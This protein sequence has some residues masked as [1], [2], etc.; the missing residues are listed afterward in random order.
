M[1]SAYW[2]SRAVLLGLF[3][4]GF[5]LHANDRWK[6]AMALGKKA[7]L[8]IKQKRFDEGVAAFAQAEAIYPDGGY[9]ATRLGSLYRDREDYA[10]AMQ[11]YDRALGQGGANETYPLR[12]RGIALCRQ[13][14]FSEALSTFES[15]M[16][17]TTERKENVREAL[18][19][20]GYH[21]LCLRD[22]GR[23]Q[24]AVQIADRG[25]AMS[26]GA[27]IF[28]LAEAKVHSEVWLGHEAIAA[29]RYQEASAHYAESEL[30]GQRS[31][32][33]R[34]WIQKTVEVANLRK[35]ADLRLAAEQSG[36]QPEY[37]HR[38]QVFYIKRSKLDFVASNGQHIAVEDEITSLQRQRSEFFLQ[39]LKKHV[40]AMSGNRLTLDF[41]MKELDTTLTELKRDFWDGREV[42]SP[43]LDS[44]PDAIAKHFCEATQSADTFWI[45]WPGKGAATTANGGASLFP[46]VPYQLYTPMRGYVT[47]PA[48][49]KSPDA[50]LGYMHEFFHDIEAMVRIPVT[51]GFLPQNR[52]KFPGWRGSGQL[53]YFAWQFQNALPGNQPA[54][55]T[56]ANLNYLS[57]H[58][59]YLTR[60]LIDAHSTVAGNLGQTERREARRLA[61]QA[62]EL[63]WQKRNVRAALETAEQAL[64]QFPHQR[65]ALL[66]ASHAAHDLKDFAKMA[67]YT[68]RLVP[69]P[70]EA[71]VYSRLAS[72]QQWQLKDVAAAAQTY[73]LIAA[74]FPAY[75]ERFANHG[76]ALMELNRLDEAQSVFE[77]GRQ[78]PSTAQK[79]P[80]AAQSA[81]WKG[82]LLGEKLGRADEALAL[83]QEAVNGGY[84]DAF[85]Q[86]HLKKY[87]GS[88]AAAP[89]LMAP[90][91][92][93]IAVPAIVKPRILH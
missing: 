89:R 2:Y 33:H 74:R 7:D 69:L 88:S 44:L 47:F 14:L 36:Q 84:N 76:R 67:E 91:P 20:L 60:E 78:S 37:V 72:V 3:L 15:A 38:I 82:Y 57:R 6:Q 4:F 31:P 26:Q 93:N 10:T 64:S 61:I 73:E 53:D 83:V 50:P 77:Q 32:A 48:D 49:W 16:R 39:I 28:E 66:I 46:C 11:H 86:W 27:P 85:V 75:Q 23:F 90:A 29:G 43:E 65:D 79:P 68:L 81:F 62:S 58:P 52:G 25:L 8:L 71:W 19:V 35:L 12:E 13:Q 70:T 40:E 42:R 51:H 59:N 56:F 80:V 92:P 30:V 45:F 5:S 21:A 87:S 63:Y 17:V 9:Y 54:D 22:A 1:I 24:E 18:Y 34:E 41:R 55:N